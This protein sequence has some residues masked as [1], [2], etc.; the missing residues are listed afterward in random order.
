MCKDQQCKPALER[1][2]LQK[3]LAGFIYSQDSVPSCCTHDTGLLQQVDRNACLP[4]LNHRV[5]VKQQQVF[6]CEM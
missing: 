5:F 2:T 1:S 3:Q 4:C 6:C